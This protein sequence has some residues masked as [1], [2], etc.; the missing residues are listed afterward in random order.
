MRARVRWGAAATRPVVASALVAV[1]VVP[2]A[3]V[4]APACDRPDPTTAATTTTTTTT[5]APAATAP[6]EAVRE[7][8]GGADRGARVAALYLDRRLPDLTFEGVALADALD[9]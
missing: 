6:A 7:P 2:A 8:N 4:T 9:F 5:T 1:A 3:L